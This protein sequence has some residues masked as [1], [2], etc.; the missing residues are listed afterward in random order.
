MEEWGG[1]GVHQPFVLPILEHIST[2]TSNDIFH[3][4]TSNPKIVANHA[5]IHPQ[6]RSKQNQA[7]EVQGQFSSMPPSKWDNKRGPWQTE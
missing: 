4:Y 2:L 1:G 6:K 7:W 5:A 3:L